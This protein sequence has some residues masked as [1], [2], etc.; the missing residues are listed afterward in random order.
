LRHANERHLRSDGQVLLVYYDVR[1][2]ITSFE[3]LKTETRLSLPDVSLDCKFLTRQEALQAAP[4]NAL[5][6]SEGCIELK[7]SPDL[8]VYRVQVSCFF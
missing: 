3:K 8:E 4:H 5:S 6:R 1:D 2:A 7:V